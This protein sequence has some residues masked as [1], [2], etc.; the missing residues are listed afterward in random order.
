MIALAAVHESASDVVDGE[1]PLR[2][3]A[4]RRSISR[5]GRTLFSANSISERRIYDF[6]GACRQHQRCKL[7]S[8]GNGDFNTSRIYGQLARGPV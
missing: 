1:P 5:A 3:R 7:A 6:Y 2:P 4:S 8:A